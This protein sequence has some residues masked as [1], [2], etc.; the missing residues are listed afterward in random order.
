M[1]QILLPN[2][3]E[4]VVFLGVPWNSPLDTKGSNLYLGHLSVKCK[5][6]KYECHRS[7]TD[8]YTFVSLLNAVC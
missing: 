2:S 7:T 1:V 5:N 4:K 6:I 8:I 3:G